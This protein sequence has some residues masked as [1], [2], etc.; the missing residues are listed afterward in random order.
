MEYADWS[1]LN[2]FERAKK[3]IELRMLNPRK[4]K[5]GDR[6]STKV[7][8]L[9]AVY[10]VITG[11]KNGSCI[12][13]EVTREMLESWQISTKELHETAVSNMKGTVVLNDLMGVLT[14]ILSGQ[15]PENLLLREE[16]HP[17]GEF[18]LLTNRRREYGAAVL[19]MPSILRQ[20]TEILR[21]ELYLVPSSVH[22]VLVLP[23]HA[24]WVRAVS[25]KELGQMVREINLS[26]VSPQDVLSDHIYEFSGREGRVKTVPKSQRIPDMER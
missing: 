20:V 25:E 7:C 17:D 14:T 4:Q 13:T 6:P 21:D 10:S 19:A 5:I 1:G 16:F 11:A 22:E 23:K 26:E 9:V 24:D 2:D 18:L 15:V 8:D 12:R 3:Y